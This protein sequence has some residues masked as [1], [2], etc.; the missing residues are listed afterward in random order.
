MFDIIAL[1]IPIVGFIC[2]VAI[3]R[4]VIDGRVKRRLAEMQASEGMVRA[5]A[6][7]DE[8]RRKHE[9]LKWGLVLGL[10]GFAL[11]LIEL[12]NLGSED[13]GAYGLL[14]AAAGVG[15]LL[16]RVLQGRDA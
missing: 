10:T 7:A 12:F 15:L 5:L 4:A 14:L 11:V 1:L 13:P 2:L 9:V 8:A 3:V 6:Q 16:N